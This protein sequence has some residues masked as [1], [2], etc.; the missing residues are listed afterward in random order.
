MVADIHGY[1]CNINGL[2]NVRFFKNIEPF[3]KT[4]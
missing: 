4:V 3:L 2:A 1:Q